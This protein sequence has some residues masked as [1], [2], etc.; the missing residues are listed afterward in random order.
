MEAAYITRILL[1]KE[2]SKSEILSMRHG[3]HSPGLKPKKNACYMTANFLVGKVFQV[4]YQQYG[5]VN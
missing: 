3:D 1:I 5:K 2:L 4:V